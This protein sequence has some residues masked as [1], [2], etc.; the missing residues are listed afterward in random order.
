MNTF[1][2]WLLWMHIMGGSAIWVSIFVILFRKRVFEKRF[3]A[4]V[5]SQREQIKRRRSSFQSHSSRP[6]PHGDEPTAISEGQDLA[7]SQHQITS[8]T[9]GSA[10]RAAQ[11]DGEQTNP[12]ERTMAMSPPTFADEQQLTAVSSRAGNGSE[13]I[14]FSTDPHFKHGDAS[15]KRRN[16]IISF[17]G[18]GA[19]PVTTSFRRPGQSFM[20]ERR[21]TEKPEQSPRTLSPSVFPWHSRNPLVREVLGRNSQFHG[22]TLEEREQLGGVEYRAITLL[23]WV[24]PLYFVLWQVLGSL[25]IGAWMAYHAAELTEANGINPWSVSSRGRFCVY[26]ANF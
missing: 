2:Q 17:K 6:F 22:L 18:V 19:S 10:I 25:G 21:A 20:P 7:Q 23:A 8:A 16:S 1:Q 12:V 13:H 3:G 4:L 15:R 9:D 5:K 14:T 26:C 11:Y 24:I